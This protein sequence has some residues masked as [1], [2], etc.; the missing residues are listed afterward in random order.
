MGMLF[1]DRLS[2]RCSS[3]RWEPSSGSSTSCKSQTPKSTHTR[4]TTLTFYY[5]TFC[6]TGANWGLARATRLY[7]SP[8][9][10]ISC[11]TTV[12]ACRSLS[13]SEKR[14]PHFLESLYPSMDEITRRSTLDRIFLPLAMVSI[15]ISCRAR[16]Y[17]DFPQPCSPTFISS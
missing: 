4:G 16:G 2:Q 15:Y 1:C 13:E 8:A 11:N 14:K 6:V 9:S 5:S 12:R 3:A 10:A 17:W 7:R